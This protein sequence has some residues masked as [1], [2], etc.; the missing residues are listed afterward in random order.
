MIRM[1]RVLSIPAQLQFRGLPRGTRTIGSTCVATV[2]ACGLLWLAYQWMNGRDDAPLLTC[3]TAPEADT[4][5]VGCP[6]DTVISDVTFASYGNPAGKCG[7]F[8]EGSCHLPTSVR[9]VE[10]ECLGRT[11]CTLT[12]APLATASSKARRG[13]HHAGFTVDPCPGRPRWLAVA[14][15]CGVGADFNVD[16]KFVERTERFWPLAVEQVKQ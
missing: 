4:L 8:A 7:S 3:A 5:T 6:V 1:L 12:A 16:P 2:V 9:E 13:G 10:Q 11:Q 14:I 15:E